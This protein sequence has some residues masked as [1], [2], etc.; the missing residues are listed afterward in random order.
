[1]RSSEIGVPVATPTERLGE[2]RHD[3]V[4]RPPQSAL[5]QMDDFV[6][7]MHTTSRLLEQLESGVSL[8]GGLGQGDVASLSRAGRA[9]HWLAT[10][11]SRT[12]LLNRRYAPWP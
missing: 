1:M 10:R 5:D 8:E 6:R 7:D 11:W 12:G 2:E 4:I 9:H 3:V